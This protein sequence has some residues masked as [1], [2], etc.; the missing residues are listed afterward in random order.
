[1]L[2]RTAKN[3][4]VNNLA[5]AGVFLLFTSGLCAQIPKLNSNLS[6]APTIF[7]DFDGHVVQGTAWN[8]DSTIRA[9]P[10]GLKASIITEVFNRVAEDFRIFNLNVTTDAAIYAKAPAIKRVR[11]I[12]TG[13]YKWYGQVGGV[14]FVNSF[15][16]GDDTPAW[17]F[18]GLIGENAKYI[19][20]VASH[21]IGHTLG[22][23][24]QSTYNKTCDKTIEYAEGKGEGEI[25]WAPIMGVGYYRNF[26]LWTIGKSSEGCNVTQNDIS[27][28]SKG[29]NN[30]G[31]RSDDHG[32]TL[33]TSTAVIINNNSFKGSGIINSASDKDLHKIIISKKSRLKTQVF[34]YSVSSGNSGADLDVLMTII[35]SS[36]DTII[37]SNPKTLL[38]A[39]VDTTLMPGTYYIGIDGT[40]NQNVSDYGSVG[41]YTFSGTLIPVTAPVTALIS[42]NIR[43]NAHVVNW[44][45]QTTEPLTKTYLEYSM[46][47][48]H[49][50]PV[51]NTYSTNTYTHQPLSNDYIHYRVKMVLPDESIYYSNTITL[52]GSN[53][54]SVLRTIVENSVQVKVRGE[55]SYQLYD[56]TGR[57]HKKGTLVTGLNNITLEQVTRGLLIFR[58]FNN[59]QQLHFRLVKQ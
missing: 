21:E 2:K 57:L 32:N 41:Y 26:T 13:T 42:G 59:T 6:A 22:L 58:V 31:M 23:Q 37:R 4:T 20:E 1:M 5:T 47:G 27:V 43:S 12:F 29:L 19:A 11:I 9:T 55:Y 15:T 48:V 28:I 24:H 39:T 17:V 51:T 44:N 33:Q 14:A 54:V 8:W 49:F 40:G 18:S 3:L 50:T 38:G 10:S 46:N 53:T 34:P 30:I 16:W 45:I 35:K 36:G 52:R 7:L 25:G 56:E